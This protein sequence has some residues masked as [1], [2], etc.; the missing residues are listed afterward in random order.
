MKDLVCR[1]CRKNKH[2]TCRH[3]GRKCC[4]HR[5]TGKEGDKCTCGTCWLKSSVTWRET[6][7][8]EEEHNG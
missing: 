6:H 1:S 7:K 8:K 2:W 4:A 3:C 5:C